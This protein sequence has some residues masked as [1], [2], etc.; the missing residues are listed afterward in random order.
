M[1]DGRPSV[2]MSP[3]DQK[4]WDAIERWREKKLSNRARKLIPARVRDGLQGAGRRAK[5]QFDAL[6]KAAEFESLFLSA[7]GGAVDFGSRVAIA[8]IREGRI[9]ESFREAGHA[10]DESLIL[11]RLRYATSTRSSQSWPSATPRRQHLKGPLPD[12]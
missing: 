4:A 1:S 2:E 9:L 6:P 5:E 12:S 3:Y 7:V 8:T 11:A 10:V